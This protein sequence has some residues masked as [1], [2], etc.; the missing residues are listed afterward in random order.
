[1]EASPGR[2]A[3]PASQLSRPSP[4]S[5]CRAAAERGWFPSPALSPGSRSSPFCASPSLLS[6]RRRAPVG[7]AG[8][9][10]ALRVCQR[11]GRGWE[12]AHFQRAAILALPGGGAG[13]VE[14]GETRG[15]WRLGS[16]T[17]PSH[18]VCHEAAS[19]RR[20]GSR[21][22]PNTKGS[23]GTLRPAAG[24]A[25]RR[26]VRPRIRAGGAG[27][28]QERKQGRA[29]WEGVPLEIRRKHEALTCPR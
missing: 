25:E 4:R 1:M 23:V 19:A 5:P 7:W 11:H 12:R 27:G 13:A 9:R 14:R 10:R 21:F 2:K 22:L 17:R 24:T 15:A 28:K 20:K 16:H 18:A 3:R 6:P 26:G 29:C 8:G